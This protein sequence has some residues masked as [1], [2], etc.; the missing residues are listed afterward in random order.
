MLRRRSGSVRTADYLRAIQRTRFKW[1]VQP[2]L[3]FVLMFQSYYYFSASVPFCHIPESLR[4]FT[5]RVT[6]IDDGAY[7]SGRHQLPHDGQ[8][9]FVEF[10]NEKDHLPAQEP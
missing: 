1:L 9:L 7:L 6:L 10:C 4:S 8:I 3:G 2:L 5:Q